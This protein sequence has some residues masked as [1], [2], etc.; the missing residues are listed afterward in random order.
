MG[1]EAKNR[2]SGGQAMA[3]HVRGTGDP[4]NATVAEAM[5]RLAGLRAGAST[6]IGAALALGL[7]AVVGG[8][9]WDLSG[10]DPAEVPI[11]RAEVGPTKII[12]ADPGGAVVPHQNIRS[13]EAGSGAPVSAGAVVIAPPPPSPKPGDVAMSDLI[14]T[15]DTS[16]PAAGIVPGERTTAPSTSPTIGTRP[17]GASDAEKIV[18]VEDAIRVAALDT[19]QPLPP[20]PEPGVPDEVL[21]VAGATDNAPGRSPQAPRRPSDLVKRH[22]EAARSLVTDA[23]DLVAAAARSPVQIQLAADPDRDTIVRLWQRIQEANRDVLRDRALAVQTTKSGGTTFFRLR[24]GPFSS[25]AEAISVCQALKAR[26]QDCIVAR[27][28]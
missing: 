24:V 16:A 13:Y 25:R 28:S 26:D 11:L 23:A 21:V 15:A 5:G 27:N 22:R 6:A 19:G 10:R 3:N 14:E 2:W 7:M 8:W 9:L 1:A 4:D 20:K 18:T 12:P 17:D